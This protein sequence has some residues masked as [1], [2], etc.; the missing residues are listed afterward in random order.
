[1]QRVLQRCSSPRFATWGSAMEFYRRQRQTGPRA[2]RLC[3]RFFLLKK[4]LPCALLLPHNPQAAPFSV[5]LNPSS[6]LVHQHS[7]VPQP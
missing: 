4:L 5:L 6:M 2:P 7:A 3:Q 1:M